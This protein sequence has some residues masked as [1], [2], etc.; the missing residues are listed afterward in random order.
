MSAAACP[1]GYAQESSAYILDGGECCLFLRVPDT[2]FFRLPLAFA[3]LTEYG[4][5]TDAAHLSDYL[6][7][8]GA[9]LCEC[10]AV[11]ELGKLCDR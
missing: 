10:G 5:E 4:Q 3:F 8:H 6:S 1:L 7:E 2:T 9:P 11:G